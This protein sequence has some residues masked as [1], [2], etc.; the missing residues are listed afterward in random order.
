MPDRQLEM[1]RRAATS[2]VSKLPKLLKE[3][4]AALEENTETMRQNIETVKKDTEA[5][6]QLTDAINKHLCLEAVRKNF[7]L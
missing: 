5:R 7:R 6:N 1:E 3:H 2:A 4:T